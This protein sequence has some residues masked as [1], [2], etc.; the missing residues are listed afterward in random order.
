MSDIPRLAQLE[1]DLN[2]ASEEIA[3]LHQENEKL[4]EELLGVKTRNKRLCSILAQGESKSGY[5]EPFIA[6]TS[7]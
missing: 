4:Q 6:S 1:E 7:L 3:A 2:K 5:L